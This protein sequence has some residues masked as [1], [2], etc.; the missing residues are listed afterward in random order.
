MQDD[1]LG[2]ENAARFVPEIGGA[3]FEPKPKIFPNVL[4]HPKPG[5]IK[6]DLHDSQNIFYSP[7]MSVGLRK[8]SVDQHSNY[9]ICPRFAVFKIKTIF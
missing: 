2:F 4:N 8:C 9:E 1:N 3:I 7:V 5:K 6:E